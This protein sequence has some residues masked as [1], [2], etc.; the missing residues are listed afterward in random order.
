MLTVYI[1][2]FL[3]RNGKTFELAGEAS[4]PLAAAG[5]ALHLLERLA[6]GEG[7]PV[8]RTAALPPPRRGRVAFSHIPL[9]DFARGVPYAKGEAGR[10]LEQAKRLF[11]RMAEVS[12]RWA[13][14]DAEALA[15]RYS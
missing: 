4:T 3:Y 12:E 6:H 10:C 8:R 1:T 11:F 13:Y 14:A 15:M 7:L 9:T 5:T 2:E